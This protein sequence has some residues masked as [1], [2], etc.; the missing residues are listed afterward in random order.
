V[1]VAARPYNL[2]FNRK[3]RELFLEDGTIWKLFRGREVLFKML[4]GHCPSI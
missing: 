2:G 4:F 3:C 1:T